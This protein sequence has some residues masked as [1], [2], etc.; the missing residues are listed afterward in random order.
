MD[1]EIKTINLNQDHKAIKNRLEEIIKWKW[2]KVKT[3]FY[4]LTWQ[5]QI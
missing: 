5:K 1:I 2:L 4:F 3:I